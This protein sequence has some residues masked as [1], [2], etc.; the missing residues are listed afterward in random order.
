M[1]EANAWSARLRA[2]VAWTVATVA[3]VVA[4]GATP[5]SAAPA[6]EHG[7]SVAV[8]GTVLRVAD[9]DDFVIE[10]DRGGYLPVSAAAAG[11]VGT[12][13]RITLR[14]SPDAAAA[15]AESRTTSEAQDGALALAA[16]PDQDPAF[17]P[18]AAEAQQRGAF[19]VVQTAA[20]PTA[21]AA[22]AP[23]VESVQS[24]DT[25]THKIWAVPMTPNSGSKSSTQSAANIQAAVN[26]L[27]SYWSDQTGGTVTFQLA[28]VANW[29]ASSTLCSSANFWQ[30]ASQGQSKAAHV[31][32]TA[33]SNHHVII[34][35]PQGFSCGGVAGQA[36]VGYSLNSGGTGWVTGTTAT[37]SKFVWNHEVGHNLSFGHANKLVCTTGIPSVES[38]TCSNNEYGDKYDV[39]GQSFGSGGTFS[40]P[41]AIFSGAWPSSDYYVAAPGS[42]EYTINVASSNSGKRAVQIVDPNNGEVFYVEARS[43]TGRDSGAPYTLGEGVRILQRPDEGSYSYSASGGTSV[44]AHADNQ[45]KYYWEPAETYTS[46]SGGVAITV[47]S[48]SSTEAVID[49]TMFAWIIPGTA[50]ITGDAQYG[51]T[52]T[53]DTSG[54]D[55]D[56]ESGITLNYQWRRG[57]TAIAGATDTTYTLTADDI[58][59]N[60]SVAITGTLDDAPEH[61][62]SVTS[63][64]TAAVAELPITTS[65]VTVTG[66]ASVG[67]ELT[68]TTGTWEPG[69]AV[70]PEQTIDL[71]YQWRRGSTNIAGATSDT[72]TVS[73]ADLGKKLS[74]RVTGTSVGYATTTVTS[75]NT[76]SV[77]KGVIEGDLAVDVA[78]DPYTLTLTATPSG[79]T[80]PGVSYHFLWYRGSKQLTSHTHPTYKL[81]SRDRNKELSVR[82]R[83]TKNNYSRIQ[84]FS[85]R[86][87]Y[88]VQ[89]TP[90]V[91]VIVPDDTL[92]VSLGATLS[93]DDQTFTA[94]GDPVASPDLSYQWKRGR[95]AI[96]GATGST[97]TITSRDL[98]KRIRRQNHRRHSRRAQLHPHQRQDPSGPHQR[99]RGNAGRGNHE[100]RRRPRAPHSHPHRHYRSGREVQ[101]P[102]VPQRTR[103]RRRDALH[104]PHQDQGCWQGHH[105]AA[106]RHQAQL[107]QRSRHQRARRH[108][109]LASA[110]STTGKCLDRSRGPLQ[111][112]PVRRLA[113]DR[114]R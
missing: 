56:V 96:R 92:K 46:P 10:L 101:L 79:I 68:A 6:D 81:R 94:V 65:P 41:N 43:K 77:Q 4:M 71:T 73:S 74:V 91:P 33:G 114:E 21:G 72:Y 3:G 7:T 61:T 48:T 26:Q 97:Y 52:L 60:I 62:A 30:F 5:A 51:S 108:R 11:L 37:F 110:L 49:V 38:S 1:S 85:E 104:V 27:S 53:A 20:L 54:W 90:S 17:A 59:A 83:V 84:A 40:A 87:N 39:M 107:H 47:A 42:N 70:D 80:T 88:T 15:V 89:A 78:V 105:R 34:V 64:P 12:H 100:R 95:H 86:T 66:S 24:P 67:A 93:V 102:V 25:A 8:E 2:V 13:Q 23:T 16:A 57:S 14:V 69:V 99:D 9:S 63:A 32:Y 31:G 36:T 58:G 82:V 106:A 22:M 45:S 50:T 103:P 113:T 29:S 28:A 55:S 44:L 109:W 112:P 75:A 35:F 19:A 76:A 98:G 111:A 18:L